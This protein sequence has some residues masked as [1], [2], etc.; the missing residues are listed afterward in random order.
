MLLVGD[1]IDLLAPHRL[2]CPKF[3]GSIAGSYADYVREIDTR[4]ITSNDRKAL[5]IKIRLDNLEMMDAIP[6]FLIHIRMPLQK[7]RQ[8]LRISL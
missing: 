5:G 6:A 4:P 3:D 8:T 2:S 7:C 1:T